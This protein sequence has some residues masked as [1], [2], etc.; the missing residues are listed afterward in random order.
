MKRIVLIVAALILPV[1]FLPPM[2]AAEEDGLASIG[3]SLHGYYRIR[4]HNTFDPGWISEDD[5]SDWWSYIDQ[6]MLLQPS[7]IIADPIRIHMELDVLNNVLFGDNEL[8]QLPVVHTERKPN[9]PEEID[10]AYLEL[11]DFNTGNIFSQSTSN[12][13]RDRDEVQPIE[14]RQLYAE[15]MLPIGFLRLGRQASHF[16]MG[17]FSNSGTPFLRTTGPGDINDIN[18]GY[19]ADGGDVYD[20]FLFGTRIAGMYYPVLIYD[21]IAEQD[22]RSGNE[23]VHSFTFANYLRGITFGDSGTFDAGAFILYRTQ[24]STDA[25]VWIY[26]AYFKLAY[27]GFSLETEALALQGSMTQIDKDTIEDLEE[28]GLPTGEG[29]GEI[30]ADAYLGAVRL[31]Y[32]SNR[33]GTGFEYGFSSPADPNPDNEFSSSGATEVALAKAEAD[34]D[35]DNAGT[36][37][38]FIDAVV[39]NQAAFGRRVN[40]FYFDPNY[41]VDL[42]CW[43]ILMESKMQN[44]MYF[45]LGGYIRPLDGMHVQLDVINSYINES[46]QAEDGSAASHDLGWEGDLRFAYTFYKHFTTGFEFGYFWPGQYFYDVYD[47]VENVYTLQLNS[48]VNF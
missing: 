15:V 24:D 12:T 21:R 19:D 35:E 38:D 46:W 33:W 40:T 29:G 31:D 32:D 13:N 18:G 1:L 17:L 23:D 48:I 8:A 6:R 42:V 10:R 20:R 47:N 4:Y 43:E 3:T 14:I 26:D 5:D 2:A 16:G 34:A 7:L 30:T 11:V 37:I 27:G 44:G 36:Q 45:K 9:A 28:S 25:E 39:D 22:F 41:N